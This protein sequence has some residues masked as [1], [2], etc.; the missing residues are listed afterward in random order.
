LLLVS[1]E[2]ESVVIGG[3]AAGL[4]AALILGR[5]RR[6]TLVI[7]AGEP[8]NAVAGGIGGLLGHDGKPPLQLYAEARDHMAKY[9]SA[10]IRSGTVAAAAPAEGGFELELADGSTLRSST[11]LLATGM[12][13]EYPAIPGAE[14]RWGHSVFHCPFCHGWE[15]NGLP[16]G[17]YGADAPAVHRAVLLTAW[18]DDVTLFTAGEELPPDASDRLGDAGVAVEPRPIEA[19]H[20]SGADLESA[21]LADGSTRRLGGLLV[22]TLL[23]QR[24]GLA[25]QLGVELAEPTPLTHDAVVVDSTFRTNITGVLAAGDSCTKMPSVA[26][27]IA[28]GSIAAGTI[29]GLLTGSI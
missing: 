3:G 16:L 24:S 9:P 6:K 27:A 14:G 2:F 7:D 19:L 29:T 21:E 20:G 17:V 11:L 1:D 23:R 12:D 28:A 22:P 26:A 4:S 15:V 18:S 8:S 10:T 25:A 13:Y 5:A